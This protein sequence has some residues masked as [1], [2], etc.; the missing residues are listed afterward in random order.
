MPE[1]ATTS[2]PPTDAPVPLRSHPGPGW[3]CFWVLIF[4]VLTQIPGALIASGIMVLQI[5]F[6]PERSRQ[7]T[8]MGV[9]SYMAAGHATAA[10]IAGLGTAQ[11]L[12]WILGMAISRRVLGKTWRQQVGWV[13]TDS[14]GL[15]MGMTMG[16]GI[17]LFAEGL[18]HLIRSWVPHIAGESELQGIFSSWPWWLGVLVIG[19][20]PGIGEELWCR[21]FL[22]Q[23][24]VKRLGVVFGVGFTSLLFG[25]MHIDPA[26]AIYAAAL[27]VFLHALRLGT[28]SLVPP[29]IAHTLNNSLSMLAVC[30]DSPARDGLESFEAQVQMHPGLVL[31]IGCLL[32]G[33]VLWLLRNSRSPNSAGSNP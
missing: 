2:L 25:I 7:L 14:F 16:L 1:P 10:L 18:V 3:A 6:D 31:L 29:M 9:R 4:L 27:G 33:S 26:Q 8:E 12:T 19:L 11:L 20:G 15:A 5:L 28:G 24:L 23:G 17:F 32:C 13:A 30:A 21:G 22:G